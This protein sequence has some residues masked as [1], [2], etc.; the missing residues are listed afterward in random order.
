MAY[1]PHDWET[2]EVI[3]EELL[4]HMEQG[5]SDNSIGTIKILNSEWDDSSH[6]VVKD[7]D[8]R[9]FTFAELRGMFGEDMTKENIVAIRHPQYGIPMYGCYYEDADD[10]DAKLITFVSTPFSTEAYANAGV[11]VFH[12]FMS[13]SYNDDMTIENA[14][15]YYT[16]RLRGA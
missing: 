2:G 5:I 1:V 13:I 7:N 4:D 8:G 9:A 14:F 15:S 10:L 11:I 6:L 16:I 12:A 3:T